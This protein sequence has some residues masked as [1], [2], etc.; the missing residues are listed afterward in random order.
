[1]DNLASKIFLKGVLS[2][3]RE[4]L[5]TLIGTL[6]LIL[7]LIAIPFTACTPE[8]T[9][10]PTPEPTPTPTPT[11]TPPTEPI[12]LKFASYFV[13]T[14]DSSL[15]NKYWCEEVAR[16]SDGRIE[17][18][19]YWAGSLLEFKDLAPGT[20]KG[21]ADVCYMAAGYTPDNFPLY[22]VV[23]SV[24]KTT[25]V[26]APARAVDK[27]VQTNPLL[28]DEW[29]RY[30]LK[31]L[32]SDICGPVI[33]GLCEKVDTLEDLQ[34]VKV[35]SA[36]RMNKVLEKLGAA[37]VTMSSA[38]LYEALQRGVIEGY[39]NTTISVTS[40][41]SLYEVAPYVLDPLMGAY[42]TCQTV[43]CLDT[44]NSLPT[45]IKDIITEVSG[46]MYEKQVEILMD[47][48]D[49]HMQ[50]LANAGVTLYVLS[51]DEARRWKDLVTPYIY[52]VYIDDMD[53]R[54]LPGREVMDEYTALV[55]KYEKES[56]YINAFDR[57]PTQK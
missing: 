1:M 26:D 24:Y 56:T 30:N 35:R 21:V 47:F 55:E 20:S 36:G 7:T 53:S 22:T 32:F 17:F 9:P 23:E 52:D 31:L 43:M 45:D 6:C 40:G 51:P 16:R 42:A 39:S 29:E 49:E 19:Y 34:G 4:K 5:L 12:V 50:K 41:Y 25:K 38:E 18:E 44:W 54:G 13:E 37:P 8:P 46:E 15:W 27:L 11:P 2:M 10:T 3:K 28:A 14:V 33:I 48:E 57:L